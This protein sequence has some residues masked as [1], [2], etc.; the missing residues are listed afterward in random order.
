MRSFYTNIHAAYCA[1]TIIYIFKIICDG[2][3][4]NNYETDLYF[5]QNFQINT[6]VCL[7]IH[8][9]CK[10]CKREIIFVLICR[11]T[12]TVSGSLLLQNTWIVKQ[13]VVLLWK[14][15]RKYGSDSY[16]FSCTRII[17][18]VFGTYIC[19]L[20]SKSTLIYKWTTNQLLRP[21]K[22]SFTCGQKRQLYR[23]KKTCSF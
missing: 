14:F 21:C 9:F 7:I 11:T 4:L 5:L 3:Q 16:S 19:L 8:T 12:R 22:N 17:L 18:E 13:T 23:K 2:L 20:L 1:L 10:V 6:T 15:W